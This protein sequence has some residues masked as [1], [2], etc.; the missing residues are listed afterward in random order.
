MSSNSPRCSFATPA[1]NPTVG[2]SKISC[3]G[4]LLLRPSASRASTR[5][6]LTRSISDSNSWAHTLPEAKKVS[7]LV[8]SLPSLN[9]FSFLFQ[10][11]TPRLLN[12]RKLGV[13]RR[14]AP[15]LYALFPFVSV[16]LLSRQSYRAIVVMPP[17]P[18][19]PCCCP[20][21]PRFSVPM[22]LRCLVI[23]VALM[24]S[25]QCCHIALLMTERAPRLS[26]AVTSAVRYRGRIPSVDTTYLE[27][28]TSFRMHD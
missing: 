13:K 18:L 8:A 20:V 16:P 28:I 24:S 3:A 2:T 5:R 23:V 21:L 17:V 4:G 19:S 12:F 1:P 6:V 15:K 7:H 9:D 11:R 14:A 27:T 22:L 26:A 25:C 10:A